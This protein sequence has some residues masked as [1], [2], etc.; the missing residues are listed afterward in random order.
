MRDQQ[1]IGE[2]LK[3]ED[4]V[5]ESELLSA[6]PEGLKVISQDPCRIRRDGFSVSKLIVT[7]LIT[8]APSYALYQASVNVLPL[9]LAPLRSHPS[10][11]DILFFVVCLGILIVFAKVWLMFLRVIA[12]ETFFNITE[13]MIGAR[14]VAVR[15]MPFELNEVVV[16]YEDVERFERRKAPYADSYSV[17]ALMRD[18]DEPIALY[19]G[20]HSDV[21]WVVSLFTHHLD[22]YH[23]AH[24]PSCP[25][26]HEPR[27]PQV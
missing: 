15:S 7:I 1:V 14:G 23:R 9:L 13:L 5:S 24:T 4:D 3:S 25:N 18:E 6:L 12:H 10:L 2:E 26:E 11:S 17:Y 16:R 21:D 20:D 27:P 22:R 19:R 8:L